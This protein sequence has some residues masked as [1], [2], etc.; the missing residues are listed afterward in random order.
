MQV[1]DYRRGSQS[2]EMGQNQTL[3]G[4]KQISNDKILVIKPLGGQ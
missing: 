3:L 4:Y 1:T 2:V